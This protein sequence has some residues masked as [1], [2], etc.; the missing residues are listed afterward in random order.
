[1][2][3][4]KPLIFYNKNCKSIDFRTFAEVRD[5]VFEFLRSDEVAADVKIL[6]GDWIFRKIYMLYKCPSAEKEEF[7]KTLCTSIEKTE[8]VV[9][10]ATYLRFHDMVALNSICLYFYS[11]RFNNNFILQ[12]INDTQLIKNYVQS[13]DDSE[14]IE[15]FLK[16]I[17]NVELYE[18]KS[19]ILDVLLTYYKKDQRVKDV[20]DRLRWGDGNPKT[21]YDDRQNVHDSKVTSTAVDAAL[22]LIDDY[23]DK[24]QQNEN[25][26]L[27]PKLYHNGQCSGQINELDWAHGFL[28]NIFVD[29]KA[30]IDAF[31]VRIR[32]D[33]TTFK[34]SSASSKVKMLTISDLLIALLHYIHHSPSREDLLLILLEQIKDML[35][36]C[37]SGYVSRLINVLQGFD[38]RFLITISF[39]AQFYAIISHIIATSLKNAP[40][41]VITG[42]MEGDENRGQYL[43]YCQ[44]VINREL[45]RMINDYGEDTV[46]SEMPEVIEKYLGV[47]CKIE[48][49]QIKLT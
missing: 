21:I 39:S 47:K 45:P 10:K 18:Q 1:M 17:D 24:I 46:N 8:N 42:S 40:D 16:W 3:D 44:R 38:D 30:L 26:K 28:K 32:I 20:Y 49:R 19:N 37:S 23:N 34:S 13:M 25:Y 6:F 2:A 27:I 31:I 48:D 43:S 33:T 9:T 41:A 35:D 22:R 15:H 5:A 11:H 7:C 36:F 12:L 29:Q 14:L 4:S